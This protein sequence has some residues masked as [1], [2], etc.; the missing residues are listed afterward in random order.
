MLPAC[1]GIR[2]RPAHRYFK[3]SSLRRTLDAHQWHPPR[4]QDSLLISNRLSR[5]RSVPRRPPP[6][7]N[8]WRDPGPGDGTRYGPPPVRPSSRSALLGK[9]PPVDA[10]SC[11][12]GLPSATVPRPR[13]VRGSDEP[14]S[15]AFLCLSPC[16]PC[17]YT[18]T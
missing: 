12:R 4:A 9:P 14:G 2:P 8:L 1:T 6:E 16:V 11:I 15:R 17:P 13:L 3:R 18:I 5:Y 10:H 7:G